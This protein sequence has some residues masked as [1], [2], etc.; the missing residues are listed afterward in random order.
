MNETNNNQSHRGYWSD[1][2]R[3]GGSAIPMG[4]TMGSALS[5]A[6]MARNTNIGRLAG[7]TLKAIGAS[8]D[9]LVDA[10]FAKGETI[11][12]TL[13]PECV[14]IPT[15]IVGLEGDESPHGMVVDQVAGATA[16]SY[17]SWSAKRHVSGYCDCARIMEGLE[18]KT[19]NKIIEAEDAQRK[20]DY[21]MA[22]VQPWAGMY[23]LGAEQISAMA[24]KSWETA[25]A[26]TD[27]VKHS[28]GMINYLRAVDPF[29]KAVSD[30]ENANVNPK[31]KHAFTPTSWSTYVAWANEIMRQLS[32]MQTGRPFRGT[33]PLILKTFTEYIKFG[34]DFKNKS[35]LIATMV[36]EL[37]S[38]Y[39]LELAPE[40]KGKGG[41]GGGK[42][43]PESKPPSGGSGGKGKGEPGE[44]EPG[45]DGEDGQEKP[46]AKE[47][48]ESP[49]G[50]APSQDHTQGGDD[51]F[52]YNDSA[53]EA[54]LMKAA[55]IAAGEASEGSA[56]FAHLDTALNSAFNNSGGFLHYAPVSTRT[57]PSK[58]P[59]YN[60]VTAATVK[61]VMIEKLTLFSAHSTQDVSFEK[62]GIIDEMNLFA[63]G[64]S[65]RVF[66]T[67]DDSDKP[68]KRLTILV[69][70]STSMMDNIKSLNGA[71]SSMN[72]EAGGIVAGIC[73]A[74]EVI[75]GL[76]FEAVAIG[77]NDRGAG[78]I[79]GV[80]RNASLLFGAAVGG[81]PTGSSVMAAVD[82]INQTR[83]SGREEYMI[84]ITD[85]APK[86]I[87]ASNS[88]T[89]IALD[90]GIHV[91]A[92]LLSPQGSGANVE[93]MKTAFCEGCYITIGSGQ[94]MINGFTTMINQLMG[95]IG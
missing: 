79:H 52:E 56:S 18:I 19:L 12:W 71:L 70:N 90:R 42:G 3:S 51:A 58:A 36:M 69:D 16:V 25:I 83:E 33:D 2:W 95:E 72:Q 10:S 37:L 82:H 46:P 44:G 29:I 68:K 49:S 45:K 9:V 78:P 43:K 11:K 21:I 76:D 67:L 34:T 61:Q 87:V 27:I 41:G 57:T 28:P 6:D 66:K 47:P 38:R 77:Y 55:G 15:W 86:D 14:V 73:E 31:H 20:D 24:M 53:P 84:I 80:G 7:Q 60:A 13:F 88:A 17:A 30:T 63:I 50:D 85:G 75:D 65:E 54:P 35:A 32:G 26:C 1:Y 92:V 39:P 93:Y 94:A 8:G 89:R 62:H 74:C 91:G 4:I 40:N 59:N 48:G 64:H 23:G 81:T 5:V 22:F